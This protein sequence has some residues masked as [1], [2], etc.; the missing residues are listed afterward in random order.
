VIEFL[1]EWFNNVATIQTGGAVTFTASAIGIVLKLVQKRLDRHDATGREERRLYDA[2]WETLSDRIDYVLDLS[3]SELYGVFSTGLTCWKETRE[4]D[5]E[6]T[7]IRYLR[8]SVPLV[9]SVKEFR[10]SFDNETKDIYFWFKSQILKNIKTYSYEQLTTS[11]LENRIEKH[12]GL[13]RGHLVTKIAKEVGEQEVVQGVLEDYLTTSEIDRIY[14]DVIFEFIELEAR[15][16]H[17]IRKLEEMALISPK[18]RKK[19]EARK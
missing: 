8:K 9:D 18:K 6:I 7:H 3:R 5:R 12:S 14:K 2:F 10:K 13:I 4:T 15:L 11:E 16:Q 17:D 1:S 19:K